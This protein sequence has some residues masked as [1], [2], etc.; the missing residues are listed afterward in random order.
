MSPITY[1]RPRDDEHRTFVRT[2]LDL[3]NQS[4]PDE[5]IDEGKAHD[6]LDRSWVADDGGKIVGTITG[7]TFDFT[8]PGGSAT[9]L[10][11]LTLVSVIPTHHRRGIL[12]KLMKK[13]DGDCR[14]RGEAFSGLFASEAAIYGRFGFGAATRMAQL[15]VDVDRAHGLRELDLPGS[16][17][18]GRMEDNVD[19]VA[20]IFERTRPLRAG[21]VVRPRHMLDAMVRRAGRSKQ[22]VFVAIH[23][24]PD[25]AD[26]YAIYRIE[27]KWVDHTAQNELSIAE[28]TGNGAVRIAL[29]RFLLELD[30]VRTVIDRN[31]RVDEPI[32][33]VFTDPRQVRITGVYDQLQLRILDPKAALAAR[34]YNCDGHLRIGIGASTFDLTVEDGKPAVKRV[35]ADADVDITP[36]GLAMA[37]LGDRSFRSLAQSGQAILDPD[38]ALLADAVFSTSPAPQCLTLF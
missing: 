19:E 29:W 16:I 9:P 5:M 37:F 35:R 10:A 25:G 4:M 3:M 13:F 38:T 23:D 31:A 14:E 33:D 22:P 12:T 27:S 21:E 18:W 2:F 32:H 24:G 34:A 26:G 17:R 8:M 7:H 6:E 1:R 20:D 11:G 15:T 36:R 28:L 30:M